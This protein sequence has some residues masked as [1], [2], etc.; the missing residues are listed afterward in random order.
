AGQIAEL[1][2][3]DAAVV[4]DRFLD[5]CL[6]P[7]V[8]K[9]EGSR[10]DGLS[11]A[12]LARLTS[13]EK[14]WP[15]DLLTRRKLA[16]LRALKSDLFSPAA[17]VAPAVAAAGCST[18][19]EVLKASEDL[20]KSLSSSDRHGTL[21]R[22]PA[23]A[24]G[25][26][27]L[28]LGGAKGSQ[29]PG[30]SGGERGAVGGGAGAG[31]GSALSSSRTPASSA[32]AVRALA[33]L[34]A[35]CPEGTAARVPEAV[36]VSFLAL[37]TPDGPTAKAE[38][39]PGAP[40]HDRANAARFRAAG[41]RLAAF[42]AARCNA[43]ML[44]MAGALLLQAVQQVLVMNSAPGSSSSEVVGA[45]GAGSTL[46]MQM[47]HAAMLEACYEAI[48]SLAVRRPELFAGDTSVPRLLFR[49]LSAKEP[50]LRV[51][52]SA[53][54]GALKGA[55]RNAGRVEDVTSELWSLLWGAA[56]SPEYRARLCA[57]EW[58][59]DL[60]DFSDVSARRLCVS[61]CD[62]K[63]MAVRSAASRG[64]QPPPPSAGTE[65]G[66][67]AKDPS[68][69]HPR[70]EAFVLGAL[71]DEAAP[72]P[73]AREG[74]PAPA[75]LKKLSP[76]ALARA[77]DFALECHKAHA[78]SS[79]SEDGGGRASSSERDGSSMHV[80]SSEVKGARGDTEEAVAVFLS[81][82]ETT[83]ASAPS[84]T[85]GQHGHAQMVLLHRSAAVALQR[86]AAGD[87]T[88]GPGQEF[89]QQIDGHEKG[90]DQVLKAAAASQPVVGV[91]ARLA[92]RGAWLQQWLG[93]EASTEIREAFAE[94][95]GAAAEFMNPDSELVPFLR[96]LGH[97]LKP[98]TMPGAAGFTN[99]AVS[100]AHGAACALGAVLAR[101]AAV[102]AAGAPDG[103]PAPS[104]GYLAWAALAEDALPAALS[105]VAAAIG[106]AVSLLHV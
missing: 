10:Y 29:A 104:P 9:R 102:N 53:A 54:L 70:F 6:Y 91:A 84:A 13:K 3:D 42:I 5:V 61:L 90:S 56:A 93:H 35:E 28:V 66:T 99:R 75:S 58:A 81:V 89:L 94:T 64:L 101:L 15:S 62:D 63:V 97:K 31:G 39:P 1:T 30:S 38:R 51:K 19:H 79:S 12:G 46:L 105:C 57:V 20:L 52:I 43:A 82:I 11:P 87:V 34:E 47:Q 41:A 55:Y 49:E 17:A 36:R 72:P 48:A 59:F 50:S 60:F 68:P 2:S 67:A 69:T 83:L 18:H 103:S 73:L 106:H 78:S 76:A 4:T 85:D 7:G 86:L 100:G 22:D 14:E 37:F 21:Q 27:K 96:A 44:P 71:R 77:L 26:L 95:A 33:W 24:S 74:E 65:G 8:L 98:C 88:D 45:G 40:H 80:A 32:L 25:L 16:I 23:V 92:S